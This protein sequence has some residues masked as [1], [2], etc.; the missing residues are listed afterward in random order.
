MANQLL[1]NEVNT[2]V[3]AQYLRR[4]MVLIS[5]HLAPQVLAT[6]KNLQAELFLDSGELALHGVVRPLEGIKLLRFFL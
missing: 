4:S 1:S 6:A 3:Q 2:L 5:H